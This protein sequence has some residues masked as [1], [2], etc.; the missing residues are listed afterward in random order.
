MSKAF[1]YFIGPAG[2]EKYAYIS[3]HSGNLCVGNEFIEKKD[4]ERFYEWLKQE[5]GK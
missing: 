4:L 1:G 5:L 2:V 3:E